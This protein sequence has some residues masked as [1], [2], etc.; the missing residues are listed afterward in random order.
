MT[1][2]QKFI[3]EY[4][5]GIQS[6]LDD[7]VLTLSEYEQKRFEEARKNT[8]IGRQQAID[9]GRLILTDDGQY[10]W[11]D[12]EAFA[13]HKYQD[14]IWEEYF[15]RWLTETGITCR[16]EMIDQDL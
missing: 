12:Q 11:K 14:P 9:E 8:D 7:W 3:W 6:T 15:N 10:T 13:Q 16:W 2:V 5:D 4:P 1:I